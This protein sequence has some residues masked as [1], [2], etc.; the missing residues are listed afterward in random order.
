MVIQIIG[1]SHY[2]HDRQ[3]RFPRE[4]LRFFDALAQRQIGF[5]HVHEVA[6]AVDIIAV[7]S[8]RHFHCTPIGGD[9]EMVQ[10]DAVHVSAGMGVNMDGD[11]EI[12]LM[13]VRK[14]CAVVK[15]D[16]RVSRPGHQHFLAQPILEEF[17]QAQGDVQD[18]CFFRKPGSADCAGILTAVAGIQDNRVDVEARLALKFCDLPADRRQ[19]NLGL[20]DCGAYPLGHVIHD[21]PVWLEKGVHLQAGHLLHI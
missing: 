17:S 16:K 15:F 6:R 20:N 13:L 5:D 1:R 12:R 7:F 8:R 21:Q 10:F 14:F 19:R 18:H 2:V 3:L 9:A 11:E 4:I